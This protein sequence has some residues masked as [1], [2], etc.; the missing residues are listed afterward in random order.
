MLIIFFIFCFFTNVKKH[1]K[2]A[3]DHCRS[4]STAVLFP[5]CNHISR[6]PG[7]TQSGVSDCW[8]S[9]TLKTSVGANLV[10]C[11]FFQQT[12]RPTDH[13]LSKFAVACWRSYRKGLTNREGLGKEILKIGR[14]NVSTGERQNTQKG[15]VERICAEVYSVSFAA[16]FDLYYI[17]YWEMLTVWVLLWGCKWSPV[18]GQCSTWVQI[19]FG[20]LRIASRLFCRQRCSVGVVSSF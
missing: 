1:L 18:W 12:N 7:A 9:L 2:S 19:R 14:N 13:T 4:S 11:F 20:F 3:S 17:V 8:Q 10:F 5:E 6:Q 15:T 16:S